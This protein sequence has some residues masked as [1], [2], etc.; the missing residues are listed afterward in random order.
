MAEKKQTVRERTQ[1]SDKQPKER[2]AKRTA[3]VAAKPLTQAGKGV[4]KAAKPFSFL[5]RPFKARPVRF[6]GRVL[7]TVL[8]IN[9]FRSSWQELRQVT[10]PNRRETFKL[11]VAVFIFAIVFG[12][13]IALVD[14]GLDKIF[15]KILL[16]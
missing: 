9:Y 14:F 2:R 5:L 6:I 11:T 10:W 7:A 15:R 8:F 12:L 13:A 1:V 16:S 4:K 3:R